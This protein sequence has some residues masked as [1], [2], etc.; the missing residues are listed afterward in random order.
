[1]A[2]LTMDGH[3]LALD[4]RRMWIVSGTIHTARVP[5]D[6]WAARLRQA[7]HAGLNTVEVPAVWALH[8]PLPGKFSFSGQNDI[9]HFIAL[10]HEEGLR[11]VLRVG[12]YVGEG[13]D[14]GGIPAWLVPQTERTIRVGTPEYLQ[15]CSRY[16]SKLCNQIAPLQATRRGTVPGP[17]VLVQVEHGWESG[18]TEVAQKYL[19]ELGRFLREGGISVPLM[20]RNQLAAGSEGDIDTWEGF[21]GLFGVVRQLGVVNPDRPRMIMGLQTGAPDV[22]GEE[23]TSRKTPALVQR[24]I[25]ETLAAGGQF[26]LAPF[27]G[28]AA[29]GFSGGRLDGH[30]CHYTTTN[31]DESGPITQTGRPGASFDAIRRV[32]TFATQFERVFAGLEIEHPSAVIPPQIV[33][34]TILDDVTG[35]HTTKRPAGAPVMTAVYAAGAPGAVSFVFT[36]AEPGGR[37]KHATT[38]MLPDGSALP[39]DLGDQPVSWFLYDTHLHGTATLD[40]ASLSPLATLG[41]TCVFF[42]PAGADAVISINGSPFEVSVPRGK[43]P[44][45]EEHEGVVLVVCSAEQ[46]DASVITQDA[47]YIGAAGIDNE[48]NPLGH[49]TFKTCTV[50]DAEGNKSTESLNT[51]AGGR[52][53]LTFD[54]WE[55]AD[56]SDYLDGSNPRYAQIDG[57]ETMEQL[58]TPS[59]YGWLRMQTKSGAAKKAQLGFFHTADRL[60]IYEGDKLLALTGA[61]AGAEGDLVTLPLKKGNQTFVALIDNRG[62]L[63]AG[64]GMGE[65]KGLFGHV[66]EV[67]PIKTAKAGNK[68]EAV[69]ADSIDPFEITE[70]LPRP[71]FGVQRGDRTDPM[72]LRW[73]FTHRKK[74]PV[75]VTVDPESPV[76]GP[77]LVLLNGEPL[78]ILGPGGRTR[79]EIDAETLNRGNNELDLAFFDGVE[80]GHEA[81]V[82]AVKVYD[83]A[84]CFTEKAELA[85]A[86]WEAPKD[87]YFEPV[88]KTALTGKGAA[89]TAGKPCWWRTTFSLKHTER[90][91]L[92][93]LAGMSKGQVYLNG[94]NICR[95]MVGD[96]EGNPVPPQSEYYLPEPLLHTDEPNELMIFDEHGLSPAKAGIGYES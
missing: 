6:L 53:N 21:G 36:D 93:D 40:Y 85:F 44:K 77:V 75:L 23:R 90:P 2:T 71:F 17:I 27:A 37:T 91:L 33:A 1:M 68:G 94:E 80:E 55:R 42:G 18:D 10:A 81:L 66:Y 87:A 38:L 65:P 82:G 5:R 78:T 41:R 15:A 83:G 95:Y 19:G 9:A 89:A 61:D 56:Q 29:M 88:T 59:G 31:R 3:S 86:R 67:E 30:A 58:G 45:V 14:L 39:V 48:G 34:P 52:T 73:A 84:A 43:L 92:L 46:A 4:G 26:N 74:S 32:C 62:R 57:P 76:Q 28:G 51:P 12:P 63:S 69:E 60:H 96:A 25:A 8:E 79:L 22:W 49:T 20:N 16:L 50:F 11:V 13:Y 72:R 7:R 54:A 47:I 24:A 35:E 64:N 70:H